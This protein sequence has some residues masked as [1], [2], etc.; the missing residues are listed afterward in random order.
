MSFVGFV[1]IPS[2][3]SSDPGEGLGGN[4]FAFLWMELGVQEP[5]IWG[6][7]SKK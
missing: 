1:G 6:F 5:P 2:S 7:P 3:E 4:G